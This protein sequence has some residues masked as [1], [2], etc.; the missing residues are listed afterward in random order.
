MNLETTR[1][2]L[3]PVRQWRAHQLMRYHGPSLDYTTAWSLIA[4]SHT[5]GEFDFVQ[6]AAH[7]AGADSEAGVHHD[8]WNLLSPHERDRRSRWLLRKGQSPIEQL[9]LSHDVLVRAGISVTDWGR[10]NR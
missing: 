1:W 7:E 3:A 2:L 6:Q 4:L 8:D 9:G 10:P 5:P